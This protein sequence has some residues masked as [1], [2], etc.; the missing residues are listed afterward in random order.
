VSDSFIKANDS[1]SYEAVIV[2][3]K[4]GG[5]YDDLVK[6]LTMARGTQ[7][8]N[9]QLKTKERYTRGIGQTCGFVCVCVC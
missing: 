6:F 4:K 3:S 2:A 8:H 1:E 5:H 9:A 7:K